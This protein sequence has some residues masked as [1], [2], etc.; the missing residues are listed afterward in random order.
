MIDINGIKVKNRFF[1]SSGALAFGNKYLWARPLIDPTIFGGVVTRT[2]TLKERQGHFIEPVK[3]KEILGQIL[4]GFQILKERPMV[5]Q[6]IPGGWINAFGWWNI[7]IDR[8]INEVYLKTQKVPK[9]VSIGG[10]L[11]E[12]YLEMIRQLNDLDILAIELN[13]SC[14]NVEIAWEGNIFLFEALIKQCREE[15]KHPLIVKISAEGDYLTRVHI[16]EDVGINAI[17]AINTIKG[18]ILNPKTGKPLLK[19]KYG[20]VSGKPIKP[21]ALRVVSEIKQQEVDLPIIG[22]GGIYNWRDCQQ[23]FWAGADVVSFGSIFFFQPWKATWITRLHWREADK[24]VQK[25]KGIKIN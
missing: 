2:L 12:E 20:G 13:V 7:G 21:F 3:P 15:S 4:W 9:I 23:F 14:P 25:I 18:L 16:A 8:Y 17:H 10:F 1:V 6:K 11:V 5:L 24:L 19:A 22:G